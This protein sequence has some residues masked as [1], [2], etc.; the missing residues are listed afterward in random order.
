MLER[1]KASEAENQLEAGV[2]VQ[3][4]LIAV[5][6]VL[7]VVDRRWLDNRLT[8]GITASVKAGGAVCKH[9][10]SQQGEDAELRSH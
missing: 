8:D 2:G 10:D 4:L 5:V 3:V 7:G 1:E 6:G 9:H